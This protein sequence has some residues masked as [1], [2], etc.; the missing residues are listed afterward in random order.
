MEVLI[1]PLARVVMDLRARDWCKL[2]YPNHPRGCPNYGKKDGC[3]PQTPLFID[4]IEPR[5]LVA[6]KFDLGAWARRMKEKHPNWSDRQARCC[7]YWQGKVRKIL[8]EVC[9]YYSRR[10]GHDAI[11]YKPEAMGVHVFATCATVGINLERNPQNIVYKVAIIGRK[12][13]IRDVID[14]YAPIKK[15]D[16]GV[17]LNEPE[18]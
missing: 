13:R 4:V 15:E 16:S 17:Y 10:F 9:G 18:S 1:R 14:H 7:L 8:R 6:V 3:P 11:I 12:K 5:L 2:P